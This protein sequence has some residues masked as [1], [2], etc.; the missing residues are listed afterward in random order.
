MEI[1]SVSSISPQWINS[2]SKNFCFSL[3]EKS[4][5][6][7]LR[8]L[9]KTWIDTR[10][11][12]RGQRINFKSQ[13]TNDKRRTCPTT[14]TWLTHLEQLKI[15]IFGLIKLIIV[16]HRVTLLRVGFWTLTSVLCYILPDPEVRIFLQSY[17]THNPHPHHTHTFV[18]TLTS[19]APFL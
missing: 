2:S 8:R 4:V 9:Q 3:L 10:E 16:W 1:Q 5:F 6:M 11:L 15:L 12:R 17:P 14:T 7:S 19:L 13:F 18:Q